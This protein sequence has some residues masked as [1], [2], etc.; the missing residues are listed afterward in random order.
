MP[1][2]K[3]FSGNNIYTF[4]DFKPRNPAATTP[5]MAP[6]FSPLQN[7]FYLIQA[8]VSMIGIAQTAYSFGSPISRVMWNHFFP[9]SAAPEEDHSNTKDFQ[10]ENEAYSAQR[11]FWTKAGDYLPT[12]FQMYAGVGCF[13]LLFLLWLRSNRVS[14]QNSTKNQHT[15]INQMGEKDFPWAEISPFMANALKIAINSNT[16]TN[17]D[18]QVLQNAISTFEK[19]T[20]AISKSAA[21]VYFINTAANL[22]GTEDERVAKA[23]EVLALFQTQLADNNHALGLIASLLKDNKKQSEEVASSLANLIYKDSQSPASEEDD[24]TLEGDEKEPIDDFDT[25]SGMNMV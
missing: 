6:H 16:L 14:V 2:L 8:T 25:R 10:A 11:D 21:L 7:A 12:R 24:Y 19:S 3:P 13:F 17:A 23:E 18:K 15:I 1:D 4:A 9:S 22:S 20:D 5:I